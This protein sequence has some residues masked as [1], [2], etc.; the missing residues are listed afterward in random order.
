MNV[1]QMKKKAIY[2]IRYMYIPVN[3][4]LQRQGKETNSR[5]LFL[6]S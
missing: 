5:A 6:F 4:R 2:G 1:L 3:F